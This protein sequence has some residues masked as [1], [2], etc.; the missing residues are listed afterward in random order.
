MIKIGTEK[1]FSQTEI[2]EN[3]KAYLKMISPTTENIKKDECVFEILAVAA[4][5]EESVD[6]VRGFVTSRRD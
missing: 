1:L 5:I 4:V 2:L 3:L 6:F